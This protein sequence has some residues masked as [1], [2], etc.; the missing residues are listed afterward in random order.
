MAAKNCNSR[1]EELKR[2]ARLRA[3]LKAEIQNMW[4]QYRRTGIPAS[5]AAFPAV[6]ALYEHGEGEYRYRRQAG[7]ARG[8]SYLGMRF[9]W[10]VSTL[11]RLRIVDWKTRELIISGGLD[12]V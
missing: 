2:V 4:A 8:F 11:G 3:K 10:E 9:G 7:R 6:V 12:A 1:D 5:E